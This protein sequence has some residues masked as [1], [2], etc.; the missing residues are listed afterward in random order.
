VLVVA[1]KPQERVVVG[2]FDGFERALKVTVLK[3][4]EGKV[5]LGFELISDD[6]AEALESS[7]QAEREADE[8]SRA[9]SIAESV[10]LV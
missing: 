2:E 6:P 3:V 4:R 7:K 5:W 10:G 1:R 8:F 9:C